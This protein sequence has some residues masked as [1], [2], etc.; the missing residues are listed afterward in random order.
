[1]KPGLHWKILI[2]LVF[3][4]VFGI[5]SPTNFKITDTTISHLEKTHF[6]TEL[7]PVLQNEKRDFA[8]TETEFLKRIKPALGP[9]FF[10]KHKN[11]IISESKYNQYLPY[12]SWFGEL[13]L[14]ALKMIILPLVLIS[15]ISGMSNLG[16]DDNL[17]RLS[18]KTILYYIIASSLAIFTGLLFV[19]IMQPGVGIDM[20]SSQIIPGLDEEL[21]F[22][23]AFMNIIPSNIFESLGK[24]NILSIIFFAIL[25]GFFITRVNDRNRI[26]LNHFFNATYDVLLKFT[27]FII[28]FTPIGIFSLT[29]A[30]V[31][32]Q[33]GDLPKLMIIINSLGNYILTIFAGLIFHSIVTLPL[34]MKFG[35]K[36]HPWLH[37]KALRSALITAFTTCSP[38]ATLSLTMSSVQKNCGVSNKISSFTLP[39]GTA[40]NLD[41]TALYECVAALFIAQAYGIDFSF[42]DQ[43]IL[44]AISLLVSFGAAG[45]PLASFATISI[46]LTAVGLP[47]EGLGLIFS[48]DRL[49]DMF[50][51]TVS[52]WSHSCGAV[53]IA[54]S[55]GETLKV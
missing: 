41:G 33:A 39:L 24:G 3:G 30:F 37:F 46:I 2:G 32:D 17:V 27:N 13:F 12:I 9:E 14:R 48:V 42:V 26:F 6:P 1:M 4:F 53:I 5:A 50:R 43:L 52:V 22:K 34:I 45:V 28:K 16:E 25:F 47:L 55:E 38:V 36:V 35:F 21:S 15:V 11:E 7:I 44:V 40:V 23:D 31:A 10:E 19:N 49:L 18:I 51:T 54:K 20:S 29:A 8:E